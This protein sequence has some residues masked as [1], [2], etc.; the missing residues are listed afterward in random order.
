ML[1]LPNFYFQNHIYTYC[2]NNTGVVVYNGTRTEVNCSYTVSEQEIRNS[3]IK[4]GFY[5]SIY[6]ITGKEGNKSCN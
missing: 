2:I 4:T 6:K 3:V 1:Q 5:W